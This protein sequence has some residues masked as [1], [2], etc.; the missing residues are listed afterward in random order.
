MKRYCDGI[1]CIVDRVYFPAS[2]F[3]ISGGGDRGVVWLL[4]ALLCWSFLLLL[5]F[6]VTTLVVALVIALAFL[7]LFLFGVV[8]CDVSVG[9]R[10]IAIVCSFCCQG[11]ECIDRMFP[12]REAVF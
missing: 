3:S 12:Q 9:V 2:V 7:L 1:E 5:L 8:V 10:G 11:K 6:F 4:A